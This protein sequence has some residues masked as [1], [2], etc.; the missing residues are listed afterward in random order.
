MQTSGV[1]PNVTAFISLVRSLPRNERNVLI[2][3]AT[4][5]RT[6]A[7]DWRWWCCCDER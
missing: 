2:A 6:A 5:Q 7:R 3:T 4:W 1:L